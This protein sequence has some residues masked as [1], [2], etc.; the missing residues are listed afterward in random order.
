MKK[1]SSILIGSLIISFTLA[2]CGSEAVTNNVSTSDAGTTVTASDKVNHTSSE[3]KGQNSEV[4]KLEN[5]SDKTN[6]SSFEIVTKTYINKNVKIT[7]PQIV[8]FSDADKQNKINNLIKN[9][10]LSD[11]QKDVSELVGYAFDNYKDAEAGLTEEVKYDIKLNSCTLLS[12]LY[13]KNSSIPESAHPST[14]LHSI[15][16]NIE[17]ETLLKFKD[18]INIDNNFA[19][20]LKNIK[21]KIWTIKLLPGI[22]SDAADKNLAGVVSDNLSMLGNKDIIDQFSS[23]DYSFYFTKDYFGMSIDVPHAA[24]DYAELEIK[25]NDIKGNI[26]TENGA[27]KNFINQ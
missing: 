15:N 12:V 21:D 7:Y 9:D 6:A 24:G 14:T 4:S 23:E 5:K 2:G 22:S 19:Q 13:V 8:N 20:K 1:V 25:Y 27:W 26:K 10:I 18:L 3:T 16:I 17:N 11:Y